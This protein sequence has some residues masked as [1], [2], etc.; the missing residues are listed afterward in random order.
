MLATRSPAGL[1]STSQLASNGF[2]NPES[3]PHVDGQWVVYSGAESFGE[4]DIYISSVNGAVQFRLAL[5]GPQYYPT[6]SG[7]VILF[8]SLPVGAGNNTGELELY[9]F[10]LASQ[11]LWRITDTPWDETLSDISRLPDGTLNIVWDSGPVDNRDV[12]GANI[13]LPPLPVTTLLRDLTETVSSYNLAQG[14]S[15]ALDAKLQAALAALEAARKNNLAT[16]CSM[17]T[18]FI[19]EVT[20]QSGKSITVAEA[21]QLLNIAVQIKNGM[22]CS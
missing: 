14:I 16:A 21:Q 5:P 17:I 19:N 13:T 4:R 2:W 10:Q 12:Y 20:A 11:R 22:G 18:A 15:N 3:S 7:N 8:S 9:M 1:W 6:I